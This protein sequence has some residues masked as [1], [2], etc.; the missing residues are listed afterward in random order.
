MD[1]SL[2]VVNRV[3]F[4]TLICLPFGDKKRVL[5]LVSCCSSLR[6]YNI[7]IYKIFIYIIYNRSFKSKFRQASFQVAANNFITL[8]RW[9]ISVTKGVMNVGRTRIDVVFAGSWWGPSTA[10]L[11]VLQWILLRALSHDFYFQE[12]YPVVKRGLT[13]AF[14]CFPEETLVALPR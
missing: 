10:S 1:I 5:K 11:L 12:R 3:A 13:A 9:H 14:K 7:Y 6:I 2:I 8:W 4:V